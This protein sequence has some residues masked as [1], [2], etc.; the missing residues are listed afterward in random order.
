MKNNVMKYSNGTIIA[1]GMAMVSCFTAILIPLIGS[2]EKYSWLFLLPLWFC[3]ISVI[4][5]RIYGLVGVSITASLLIALMFLKNVITPLFMSFGDGYFVAAVD[6]S[7]TMLPAILLEIYEVTAVFTVLYLKMPKLKHHISQAITEPL[8]AR[9]DKVKYFSIVVLLLLGIAATCLLLYPQLL[10]YIT[11]GMS[12]DRSTIIQQA[13]AKILMKETTPTFVYYAYT[14]SVNIL[15][16]VIPASVMFRL[17]ISKR[18]ETTK[19]VWSFLAIGVSTIM[20]TDTVAVSVYI[21]VSYALLM[22]RMYPLQK[23]KILMFSII[24]VGVGSAMLLLVKTFGSGADVALGEIAYMLQAY[25]SGPENVAVALA[26]NTPTS[27]SEV[28]GDIFKFIPY[29]M[30]F[31]K[32]LPS[33]NV[34][35]NQTYWGSSD[36]ITQIIPMISQGARHFTFVLAPIYTVL[37][38]VIAINWETKA[39]YKGY[40]FDYAVSAIACVCLSMSVAMY[41]ASLCLQTYLNYI[42]PIQI[43]LWM[44]RKTSVR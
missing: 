31:F 43:I 11:V 22:C 40:L 39:T 28:G 33:S 15:R 35:F 1:F 44:V 20:M 41:S 6:T 42:L 10:S 25:F 17:Y 5:H 27:L 30:Y 18:R 4:F 21:A 34:I 32:D 14:L 16:W 2:V 29:L 26:I 9:K 7:A 36:I 24:T 3:L 23:K 8:Y 19:I 12:S 38:S 37:I 13:R